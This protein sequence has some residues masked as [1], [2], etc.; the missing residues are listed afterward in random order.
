MANSERYL[1][2]FITLARNNIGIANQLNVTTNLFQV[3]FCA[4]I[5]DAE[6]KRTASVEFVNRQGW[7]AT[8]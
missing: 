4:E 3:V 6:A 2:C 7:K 5:V 1:V 8:F